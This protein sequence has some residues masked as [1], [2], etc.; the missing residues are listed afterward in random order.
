M[1]DVSD[2]GESKEKADF[3]ALSQEE[4]AELEAEGEIVEKKPAK[5]AAKKS[6]KSKK[7]EE[8]VEG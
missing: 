1:P 3:A 8:K 7:S 2:D 4:K 6:R 5:K